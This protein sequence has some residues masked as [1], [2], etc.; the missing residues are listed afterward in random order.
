LDTIQCYKEYK[1]L[2]KR[3]HDHSSLKRDL[4]AVSFLANLNDARR[5]FARVALPRRWGFSTIRYLQHNSSLETIGVLIDA[6]ALLLI[7]NLPLLQRLAHDRSS[8]FSTRLAG[9]L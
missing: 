5:P 9:N 8:G 3:K 4:I 2:Q 7:T 1:L 6:L